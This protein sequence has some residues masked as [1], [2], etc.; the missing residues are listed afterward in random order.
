V[1]RIDVDLIVL[2]GDVHVGDAAAAWAADLARRLDAP[3]V[4]IAGNHEHY[5]A[6]RVPARS[7]DC[8]LAA[9]RAAAASGGRL[10]FLERDTVEIAG[11]TVIGATLWSDFALFGADRVAAAMRYAAAAMNDFQLIEWRPGVPFTPSHARAEFD[12]AKAFLEVALA[13]PRSGPVL[14]ATHHTSSPCSVPARFR[15]DLLS[16]AFSSPL[17]ALVAESGAALW[18]HGHTHD[19]FDYVIGG[20]R[21]VCNPRGYAGHALNPWFD[22]ALVIEIG[23][24]S[25]GGAP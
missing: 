1:P 16:A 15:S 20:T 9:Y 17:D 10:V 23:G 8:T 18:V 21:V 19:S 14:V 5:A 6:P 2:A 3:V 22:P 7:M 11:V 13:K 12:Q 24:A 4:L 25:P